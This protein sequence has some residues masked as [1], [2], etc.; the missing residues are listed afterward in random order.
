MGFSCVFL[1]HGYVMCLC[2]SCE[3]CICVMRV[4]CRCVMCLTYESVP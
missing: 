2:K 4:V 1:D 3:C